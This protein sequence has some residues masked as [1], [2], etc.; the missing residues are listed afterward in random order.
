MPVGRIHRILRDGN[1]ADRIGAEAPVY[2]A[3]VL[4]ELVIALLLGSAETAAQHKK[5]R[6][7]PRF[8]MLALEDDA[9]LHSLFKDV[10]LP[11]AGVKPS[12]PPAKTLAK[13][14]KRKSAKRKACK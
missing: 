7:T 13:K 6:I 2:L 8:I 14:K 5:V 9:S 11:D 12:T 10:Q 1:F 4:E 3:A